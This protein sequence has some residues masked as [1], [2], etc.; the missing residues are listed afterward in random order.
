MRDAVDAAVAQARDLTIKAEQEPQ[1]VSWLAAAPKLSVS[2]LDSREA[3][4]TDE[5][6]VSL[7]LPIKSGWLRRADAALRHM[8]SEIAHAY[9]LRTRWFYSG[10]L[11]ETLW[12]HRLATQ[13]LVS[14]REKL[15]LLKQLE[16]QQQDLA[17]AKVNSDLALLLVQQERLQ[18]E[19]AELEYHQLSE[20]WLRRYRELTGLQQLPSTIAEQSISIIDSYQQHPLVRLLDL[21]YQREK[22]LLASTSRRAEPWTFSVASKQL[23]SPDLREDQLGISLEMPLSFLMGEDQ[24]YSSASL[25][26]SQVYWKAKDELLEQLHA[27]RNKIINEVQVLQKKQRLLDESVTL[28]KTLGQRATELQA[29]NEINAEFVLRRRLA[30][31]D[32]RAAAASNRLQ[33]EKS[34]ALLNQARGYSL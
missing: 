23:E 5:T 9:E 3:I 18:A 11:R 13:K 7:M 12:S 17:T 32:A 34:K 19:L 28:S 2:Y 20:R 33:V 21:E 16:R 29:A 30:A 25:Q 8:S 24:S 27:Q 15:Q 1:S 26:L 31:V 6:E 22:E 10:V 14:I 4:G